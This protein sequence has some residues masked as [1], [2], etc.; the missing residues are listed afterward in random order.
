MLRNPRQA[1]TKNAQEY[2]DISQVDPWVTIDRKLRGREEDKVHDCRDDM[3]TLLVFA[4][5][6]SAV[7]VSFLIQSL[8]NLQE[9]YQKTSV[10]LLRQITSQT[11]SYTLSNGSLNSTAPPL[12]PSSPFEAAST[13]V[14]VNICWF[15]SLILSLSTASFGMLVKQWLREYLATDRT[16]PEERIRILHF[17]ARGVEDWKLFEIAA[18]LPLF[19]QLSLALFFVGLCYLASETHPKLRA[20]SLTLVSGWAFLFGLAVLAPLVSARCPYKTTFLKA[21]FRRVRPHLRDRLINPTLRFVRHL[22]SRLYSGINQFFSNISKLCSQLARLLRTRHGDSRAQQPEEDDASHSDDSE[23][24]LFHLPYPLM[25]A[26]EHPLMNALEHPLVNALEHP[27]YAYDAMPEEDGARTSEGN[28]LQIFAEVD[29]VLRDDNLLVAVRSALQRRRLVAEEMLRFVVSMLHGR[30]GSFQVSDL[31]DSTEILEKFDELAPSTRLSFLNILSDALQREGGA[32]WVVQIISL[33]LLLGREGPSYLED[34]TLVFQHVLLEQPRCMVPLIFLGSMENTRLTTESWQINV[35][36][37]LTTAFKAVDP[38]ILRSVIHRTYVED[39]AEPTFESK[40]Y[41][42]LLNN[43]MPV[44]ADNAELEYRVILRVLDT[45]LRLVISF[46]QGIADGVTDSESKALDASN[47]AHF[48]ELFQFLLDAFPVMDRVTSDEYWFEPFKLYRQISDLM[49]SVLSTPALISILLECLGAHQ[50]FLSPL[51]WQYV[52]CGLTRHAFGS[53]SADDEANILATITTF[54][55][56]KLHSQAPLTAYKTLICTACVPF[57][58]PSSDDHRAQLKHI[59]SLITVSLNKASHLTSRS[60]PLSPLTDSESP[61]HKLLDEESNIVSALARVVLSWIDDD[62]A[63][64]LPF[65][66]AIRLRSYDLSDSDAVE[67]DNATYYKWRDLFDVSESTYTDE[68]IALLRNLS[69]GNVRDW[70]GRTFWR[71]RRLEDMERGDYYGHSLGTTQ[72]AAP[73]AHSAISLELADRS[74][75][76]VSDSVASQVLSSGGW[77]ADYGKIMQQQAYRSEDP[78]A[79]EDPVVGT[80][81]LRTPADNAPES[82]RGMSGWES[83]N[84]DEADQTSDV[85]FGQ[86]TGLAESREGTM[87]GAD[88]GYAGIVASASAGE[89]T[90]VFNNLDLS[91]TSFYHG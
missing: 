7:L 76:A 61:S 83:Q 1:N 34:M 38:S 58:L 9:N 55:R 78:M 42:H 81:D 64:G 74:A 39:S 87:S 19:L 53:L 44:H 45:L 62:S 40:T 8:Q 17:R 3:D 65:G 6:Y 77:D 13:D 67:E 82:L 41:S 47:I 48:M 50:G 24:S 11:S 37:T 80:E 57:R 33:M 52:F 91:L 36:L 2:Q 35:F 26:L 72:D 90:G 10:D 22:S 59:F 16:A 43:V 71:I 86:M 63:N 27:L 56:T 23:H 68:L 85:Q 89:R 30:L 84:V 14:I 73:S 70:R 49:K 51:A 28:D 20:T 88:G 60:L 5:L 66:T 25:N 15:A 46:L 54:F 18:I 79:R 32:I 29:G 4:G 75:E 12:S 21:A 31:L 69:S